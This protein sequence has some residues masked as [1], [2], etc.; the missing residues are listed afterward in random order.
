VISG[1]S[2]DIGDGGVGVVAYLRGCLALQSKPKPSAGF[3]NAIAR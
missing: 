3:A 1:A 2:L